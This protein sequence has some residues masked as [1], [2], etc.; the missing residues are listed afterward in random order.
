LSTATVTATPTAS[1]AG[2]SNQ[3]GAYIAA[4]EVQQR[5]LPMWEVA[6]TCY[7]VRIAVSSTTEL[8]LE[9]G[10]GE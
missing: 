1:A 3:V 2:L 7:L 9:L 6:Q 8:L 4:G 5:L 10:D